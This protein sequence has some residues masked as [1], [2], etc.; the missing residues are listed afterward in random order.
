MD[1]ALSTLFYPFETGLI[2]GPASADS[3]L[4]L[5]A[6]L[7]RQLNVWKGRDLTLQQYFK[8]YARQLQDNEFSVASSPV[9]LR[10][11][12][13]MALVLVPKN[14]VEAAALVAQALMLL[15]PGGLLLCAGDNKAGGARLEKMLRGFGLENIRSESKNK[16]RVVW[17]QADQ[18]D[19][20]TV[21]DALHAGEMQKILNGTFISMPGIFGW[22]KI[23]AGSALL[24]CHLPHDLR[25]DGA[26]FGCGYG[27]LARHV[28]DHCTE[29]KSLVCVDADYCAVQACR[30]NLKPYEAYTRFYW[31]D[32]T[33]GNSNLH[34]L[35]FIVMNPPFH[36]GRAT[37]IGIGRDFIATAAQSLRPGGTL[38]MVANAYLPYE[39]V[40]KTLFRSCTKKFEG[41]GFKI[42]KAE[43]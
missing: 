21:K 15:E 4:F 27:Y 22:D 23:D 6:R 24:V 17:T 16:A 28:L 20:D 37:D 35:D 39:D 3:V 29:I 36:E 2:D 7:H 8:P 19:E 38:W 33:G 41:A 42:L 12:H 43:K 25:G 26:D 14:T 1:N 40:L 5:G 31:E 13:T 9:A 10:K 32:L 30:E 34:D 11:N 18:F